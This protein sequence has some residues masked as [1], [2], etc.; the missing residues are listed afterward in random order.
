MYYPKN[1]DQ[2]AFT[3]RCD[4]GPENAPRPVFLPKSQLS[5]NVSY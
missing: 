1:G 3:V 2:K 4:D 5:Q